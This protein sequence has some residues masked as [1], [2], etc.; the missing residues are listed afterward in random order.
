MPRDFL[1]RMS[2]IVEELRPALRIHPSRLQWAAEKFPAAHYPSLKIWSS[3][4]MAENIASLHC[5]G[6]VCVIYLDQGDRVPL[7]W[8]D[9]YYEHAL[10]DLMGPAVLKPGAE[11]V[12]PFEPDIQRLIDDKPSV[13]IET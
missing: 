9:P 11:L 6:K 12:N 5:G 1:S 7:F 8:D 4:S 3:D 13:S 2:R 10:M